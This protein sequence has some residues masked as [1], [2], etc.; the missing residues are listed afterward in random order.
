MNG[1][2]SDKIQLPA[3]RLPY[4][5]H[6]CHSTPP[7]SFFF[8][9]LYLYIE[10]LMYC[11]VPPPLAVLLLHT[12][13]YVQPQPQEEVL[14]SCGQWKGMQYGVYRYEFDLAMGREAWLGTFVTDLLL[15]LPDEEGCRVLT[16]RNICCSYFQP[17]SA[18]STAIA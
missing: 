7:T 12:G 5:S 2:V 16:L 10:A 6:S 11:R 1:K 17:C 8:F 3:E 14:L 13:L 18:W 15:F 4:K 9:F